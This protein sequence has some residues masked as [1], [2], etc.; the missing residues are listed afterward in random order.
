MTG[1]GVIGT[2]HFASY[3]IAA[4]RR[5][6]YEGDIFLSPRNAMVAAK[7]ARGHRCQI[8]ASNDDVVASVDVVLLSVRP[9]HAAS[10]LSGLRWERRH[11]ALSAMAGITLDDLHKLV[12]RAGAIHRIMAGSYIEAA[13]GPVALYPPADNLEPLLSCAGAVVPLASEA[14]YEAAMIATCFSTW[15]YDLADAVA[16]E[17]ARH[18]LEPDAARALTLGNIAGAAGLALARPQ[19]LLA[20]ISAGIATERTFTKLGLEHLRARGFD[21]PWR[22]AID[23]INA[24]L[25]SH[26]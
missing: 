3:F 23:M 7:L 17:L 9:E 20:T 4:L 16:G 6:G 21:V 15:I 24:R 11:T 22:E 26:P 5:G 1:L 8:V 25:R 19:E 14:A 13:P 2:G 18:G 12:P 10:A